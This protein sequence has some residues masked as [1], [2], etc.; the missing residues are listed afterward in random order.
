M[1]LWDGCGISDLLF[2]SIESD[3]NS[4]LGESENSDSADDLSGESA[5]I[6]LS[7]EEGVEEATHDQSDAEEEGDRGEGMIVPLKSLKDDIEKGKAAR[8]QIS[9][10][11]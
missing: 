7:E 4:D 5:E 6:T 10:I 3:V 1:G 2:Y 9:K 8:K 11:D